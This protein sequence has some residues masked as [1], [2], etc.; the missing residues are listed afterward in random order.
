M[1]KDYPNSGV[2]FAA[3]V[4]KNPKAPDYT[5]DISI[6]LGALGL[7]TGS[8]KVR[9]AGWKRTAQNGNVFLSL[10]VDQYKEREQ[11]SQPSQPQQE[12]FN[13]DIPF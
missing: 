4:K 5:G 10:K 12:D 7:G 9:L 1:S 3:K 2:L 13:D 6:D 8:I 11:Y